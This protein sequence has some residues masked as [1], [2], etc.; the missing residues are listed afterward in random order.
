M[1]ATAI[2]RRN[3]RIRIEQPTLTSDGQGGNTKAWSVLAV[4]WALVEP[5]TQREAMQAAQVTAVLS[6]AIT[7]I[8]RSD[9]SV[10]DRIRIGA[11]TLQIESYQDQDGR[12]DEL[13]LL[14]S[15]VQA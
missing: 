7:I 9:L 12:K 10:K 11:R 1:G 5:L 8:F 3:Q 15:E 2:G 13:R 14:C 4:T 6:T